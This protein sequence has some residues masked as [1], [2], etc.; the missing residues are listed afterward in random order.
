MLVMIDVNDQETPC[1]NG[2]DHRSAATGV[3]VPSCQLGLALQLLEEDGSRITRHLHCLHLPLVI[4]LAGGVLERG[5]EFLNEFIPMWVSE[6][7]AGGVTVV[8]DPEV[9]AMMG[10]PVLGTLDEEGGGAYH[11]ERRYSSE[12]VTERLKVCVAVTDE[13][14]HVVVLPLK[15]FGELHDDWPRLQEGRGFVRIP[16][17]YWSIAWRCPSGW[18]WDRVTIRIWCVGRCPWSA[19]LVRTLS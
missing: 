7:G 17:S 9:F 10:P 18:S 8:V 15:G 3:V 2:G 1:R 6:S 5:L 12:L 14:V 16:V 19:S 11:H 4:F 13:P